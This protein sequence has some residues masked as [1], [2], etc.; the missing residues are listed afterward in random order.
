MK[1]IILASASPR[2]KEL[3]G[4]LNTEFQ[5]FPAVGEEVLTTSDPARAVQELS[6]QK[7]RE[8]ACRI[9]AETEGEVLVIGAD[10]VVAL[11]GEILGK[12]GSLEEAFSMIE[13]LQGRTH[14][15]FTGVT[16]IDRDVS[17]QERSRTFAEE[18]FVTV[19][20]MTET[21][22]WTYVNRGESL[23]KAGA[24]GIQGVFGAFVESIQGDYNNV[25]GLP[26]SR[27][28]R[29]LYDMGVDLL[30]TAEAKTGQA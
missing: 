16:V 30:A 2:R 17:G 13:K 4:L 14:S 15:V 11:D 18:T 5:I 27:L 25:V 23:D 3:L 21:Q 26:V 8:V 12:P 28:Y 1:Q 24:Y 22:I 20:P 19:S 10:T 7:A 9:F 29:E 6:G